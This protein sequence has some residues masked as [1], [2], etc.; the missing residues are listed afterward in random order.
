MRTRPAV[1][2]DAAELGR[3]MVESWL[4]AHRGQMPEALW[5]KRVAEWTPEV[6]A[7]GWARVL[8]AQAEASVPDDVL[9]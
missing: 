6:S 1:A 2:G 7:A 4:A 3:V 9:L 8:A 5:E